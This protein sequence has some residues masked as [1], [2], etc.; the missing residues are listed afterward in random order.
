MMPAISRGKSPTID[1][2][3]PFATDILSQ[4]S[5]DPNGYIQVI[6][7][8]FTPTMSPSGPLNY[9]PSTPSFALTSGLFRDQLLGS[10]GEMGVEHDLVEALAFDAYE[11]AHPDAHPK[12]AD[13]YAQLIGYISR[14]SAIVEPV[15]E[16]FVRLGMLPDD[17]RE[18]VE[19]VV[20]TWF[21]SVINST[22]EAG[23]M[24]NTNALRG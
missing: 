11:Q 23:A 14:A 12:Y 6:G 15:G 18:A 24:D 13:A 20:M 19:G 22:T 10:K 3:S 5:F 8:N 17:K 1:P 16:G 2:I 9:W 4:D 7:D 21:E